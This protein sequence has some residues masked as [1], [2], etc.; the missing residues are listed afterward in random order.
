MKKDKMLW[1]LVALFCCQSFALSVEMT[2][3]PTGLTMYC[4]VSASSS[5]SDVFFVWQR[6]DQDGP[7]VFKRLETIGSSEIVELHRFN[8]LTSY[9]IDLF[10]GNTLLAATQVTSGSSGVSAWDNGPA[11]TISG[12]PSF[13]LLFFDLGSFYGAFDQSGWIVWAYDTKGVVPVEAAQA[14]TQLDNYNFG[15]LMNGTVIEVSPNGTVIQNGDCP[16]ELQ[17]N[18][19]YNHECRAGSNSSRIYSLQQSVEYMNLTWAQ[20]PYILGQLINY[21]DIESNDYINLYS[22]FELWNPATEWSRAS[23]GLLPVKCYQD[24]SE[25]Q[26]ETQDWS[27]CNSISEGAHD[28]LMIS[29]RSLSSI[30]SVRKDGSGVDWM[31]SVEIDSDYT[32]PNETDQFYNQHDVQQLPNGN[33]I[34]I[35]NGADRPARLGV[36]SRAAEYVIDHQAK[37]VELVWEF[38]PQLNGAQLTCFHG[39]SVVYKPWESDAPIRFVSFPC[40]NPS[41]QGNCAIVAYESD[42]QGNQLAFISIS[43]QKSSS[44]AMI[45]SYRVEPLTSIQGERKIK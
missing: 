2:C 32:F 23:S 8:P 7:T 35:D 44:E 43:N 12:S 19:Y 29:S 6:A 22:A 45:G 18:S 4:D 16:C 14:K 11:A 26:L 27:H 9:Q 13:E 42:E 20:E 17:G 34:L 10:Q 41:D 39:G 38:L 15:F 37:T 25:G 1:M 30:V 36:F 40:D 33:I 28:N 24:V 3:S 5:I 31:V 21:W